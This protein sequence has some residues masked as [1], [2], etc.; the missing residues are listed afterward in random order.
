MKVLER[1]SCLALAIL[2]FVSLGVGQTTNGSINGT[3]TDPS[4][5]AVGGVQVSSKDTGLQRTGTSL[6]NGTYTV[7]QLPPGSYNVTI[8]KVGFASESRIGVELLVNQNATLD[9]K[10]SVA[11]VSQTVEVTGA[12]PQLDTTS[13]TL[14]DV[15]QHQQ[16]VD[17]PLNGRSF[18]QLTLLTPGAA[19]QQSG[20]QGAFT[21]QQ[22]A[23][24][25]SPSVNGPR[26]Q[27]NNFTMDGVL[28][29]A[30]YTNTWVIAPPPDALQEFNVQSHI[31]DSEFSISSGANIDIATRS[32]TNEFHGAVWEFFR[33]DVL[34]ARNFFDPTKP[35]YRQNQY[36]VAFGGPIIKNRTWFEA[37]WEGFR[38]VQSLNNFASVPTAAMRMGDFSSILGSQIGTDSLG[39]PT[40]TNEIFDPTTSRP[41]PKNPGN[42]IRDQFLATKFPR[43]RSIQPVCWCSRNTIR[44]QI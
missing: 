7:P 11:A 35:P 44:C 28:N 29:N 19:P 6:D 5:S 43:L 18:T 30:I 15:V 10:L 37:Y 23:G 4:G 25:I 38:S 14:G 13:A 21:V 9:F 32:G 31:T 34:D 16:I 40:Y 33:N 8:Q 3:I 41:D 12:P 1:F 39:R 26:G 24:S 36:G 27:Q 42:V 22:G 2:L 20:Q 17:L